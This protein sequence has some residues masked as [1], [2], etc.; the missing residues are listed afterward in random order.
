VLGR[1][2]VKGSSPVCEPSWTWCTTRPRRE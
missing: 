1:R 2:M